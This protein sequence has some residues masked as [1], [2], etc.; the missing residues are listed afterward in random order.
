MLVVIFT[1]C[2]CTGLVAVAVISFGY[3][4][5]AL[6]ALLNTS[7]KARSSGATSSSAVVAGSEPGHVT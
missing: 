5:L 7:S 4:A 2:R 3:S 6:W 1:L